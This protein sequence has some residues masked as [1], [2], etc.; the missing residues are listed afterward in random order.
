M[1]VTLGCCATAAFPA[2]AFAKSDLD[3]LELVGAVRTVVTKHPQLKTTHHFDR[4]GQL[5]SLELVPTTESKSV[6]YVYLHDAAGRLK[7]EQT[8]EPDGKMMYRKVFGYVIDEHGRQSAQI[9]A[10]ETGALAHADFSY[11]DDRGVLAEEL[12][13]SGQGVAEKSLYD[14]AG[15]LVYHARYFQGRLVLEATY[16]YAPLG[17]LRESR[18]YGPDGELMRKDFYHYDHTG[19]RSEEVSEFHRQS[20]LRK[21]VITYEFDHAGNWIKETIQRW[22][23]DKNGGL[24]LTETV[25]SRERAITYY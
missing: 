24:V 19:N 22:G 15:D 20:H 17:R 10:T 16:H 14:V 11:Y 23:E 2:S 13:I 9:A 3:R 1:V 21:S 8:Y 4:Q 18:Y 25:V 7:E 6:R 12:M 5:T